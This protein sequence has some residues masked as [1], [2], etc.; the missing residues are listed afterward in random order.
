MGLQPARKQGKQP[1]EIG[2][3]E[4]VDVEMSEQ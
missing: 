2:N 1:E 3:H 4:H